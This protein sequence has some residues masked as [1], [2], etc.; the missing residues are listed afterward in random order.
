MKGNNQHAPAP[1]APMYFGKCPVC[2][3]T[4]DFTTDNLGRVH[5]SCFRC[6]QKQRHAELRARYPKLAAME[7]A[8]RC[9]DCHEPTK[10]GAQAK[11]CQRCARLVRARQV[12]ASHHALRA[13]TRAANRE[14]YRR[15]YSKTR[16]HTCRKCD[17][18]LVGLVFVCD[19][20]K[21]PRPIQRPLREAMHRR[22]VRG[23]QISEGMKR[24]RHIMQAGGHAA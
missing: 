21:K 7:D 10:R 2:R 6:E 5:P 19:A 9:I 20:C 8:R 15:L 4:L 16:S 14:R 22:A 1:T 12:E 17:T 24:R 3:S 13:H 18:V 11:R 23:Q